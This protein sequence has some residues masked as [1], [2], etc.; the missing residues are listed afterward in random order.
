PHSPV[1]L[2]DS[3]AASFAEDRYRLGM[4]QPRGMG[5]VRSTSAG[6]PERHVIKI[7]GN[8]GTELCTARRRR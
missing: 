3:P 7:E 4:E 8:R 5:A 2:D 6:L 1:G